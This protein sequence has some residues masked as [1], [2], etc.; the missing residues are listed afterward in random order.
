[1]FGSIVVI[2]LLTLLV[3]VVLACAYIGITFMV[4]ESKLSK[5]KIDLDPSG[6]VRRVIKDPETTRLLE[7][8]IDGSALIL[9]KLNER[10]AVDPE[11][12][13]RLRVIKSDAKRYLDKIAGMNP[14]TVNSHEQF[15]IKQM[16]R[17]IDFWRTEER[18]IEK[19]G[20]NV[21]KV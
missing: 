3:L 14:R 17:D 7:S 15:L 2:S 9:T 8:L 16:V 10:A 13:L 6:H 4:R 21:R 11:A 19:G 12:S 5:K 20:K 18:K 1:M